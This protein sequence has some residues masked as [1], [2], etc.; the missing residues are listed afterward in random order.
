MARFSARGIHI[1]LPATVACLV[2]GCGSSQHNQASKTSAG[3]AGLPT[4]STCISDWNAQSSV[5]NRTAL[6]SGVAQDGGAVTV[7]TYT[8]TT[9]QVPA[10]ESKT[11][12]VEH[13]RCV[14]VG[15]N[16][17]L[18]QGASGRWQL[19]DGVYTQQFSRIAVKEGWSREHANATASIGPAGQGVGYL[20]GTGQEVIDLTSEE[21]NGQPVE[22]DAK[23]STETA[24][25]TGQQEA[26]TATSPENPSCGVLTY[27]SEH[28]TLGERWA[29]TDSGTSCPEAMQIIRDD[30]GGKGHTHTGSDNAESY[31]MV[32]GWRCFGPETGSIGCTSG[33]Q[34]ITGSELRGASEDDGE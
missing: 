10:P 13:G 6:D 15:G 17:F 8:G 33:T 7:T 20:T 19:T 1:A 26:S 31:T 18:I 3:D 25:T 9:V 4:I 34:H 11:I 16:L 14:V 22:G 27:H 5:G 29:I 32:N 28:W 21:V 30:F 12:V 24:S 23:V 2:C